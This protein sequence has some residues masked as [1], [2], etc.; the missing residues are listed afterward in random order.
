MSS[1]AEAM[2]QQELERMRSMTPTERFDESLRLGLAAIDNY[3]A[4]H[5][6]TRNEARKRLEKAGEAGRR[7]LRS[8][9]DAE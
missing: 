4:A 1:L 9:L 3:A 5:G 8:M 7:V 6:V 2:R